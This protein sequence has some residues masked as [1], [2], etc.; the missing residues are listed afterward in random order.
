MFVRICNAKFAENFDFETLHDDSIV[1]GLVVVTAQMQHAVDGKVLN[2]V[3]NGDAKAGCFHAGS[4]KREDDIA[5]KD[6]A[7][8]RVLR[9]GICGKRENIGRFVFTPVARIQALHVGVI[10]ERYANL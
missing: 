10:A 2:V 8:S 7:R 1:I 4:L 9:P 5:E 3:E 6:L